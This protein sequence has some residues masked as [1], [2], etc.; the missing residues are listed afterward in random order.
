MHVVKSFLKKIYHHMHASPPATKELMVGSHKLMFPY[1][2]PLDRNQKKFKRYNAAFEH[3]ATIIFKKYP[4]YTAI[5]IG[6][7]VGDTAALISGGHNT[8]VLC[9]EGNK[10]YLEYLKKNAAHIGS[11]IVIEKSFV[12]QD[13]LQLNL[14]L[15]EEKNG[16]ASIV[17]AVVKGGHNASCN[18]VETKSLKIIMQQYP[19]FAASKLLKIDTDGFD[20]FIIKHSLDVIATMKPVLFFE[21]DPSVSNNGQEDSLRV[22]KDLFGVGY[23]YHIVY[24]N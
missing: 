16:T 10:T 23:K 7:N 9:I 19:D 1:D 6:A 8:P 17:S 21:Y 4:A 24:D 18:S 2:H 13:N 20:F 12:G 3:I 22:M 14:D 5:D 15:M 11:H